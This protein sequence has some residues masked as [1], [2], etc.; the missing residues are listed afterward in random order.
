MSP[1][2]RGFGRLQLEDELEQRLIANG[3]KVPEVPQDDV[4]KGRDESAAAASDEDEDDP[5]C[6]IC[7][8]DA[9][10]RCRDCDNDLFCNRCNRETHA[11]PGYRSHKPKPLPPRRSD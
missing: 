3:V 2:V 8:A 7:L 10:V 9:V 4:I 6:C 5:F 1:V 11:E